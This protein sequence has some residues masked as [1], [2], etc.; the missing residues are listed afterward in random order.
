MIMAAFCVP[1]LSVVANIY[2][3][4]FT[5]F[6]KLFTGAD[7]IQPVLIAMAFSSVLIYLYVKF[8]GKIGGI[9][10]IVIGVAGAAFSAGTTLGL[11]ILGFVLA[12]VSKKAELIVVLN[13]LIFVLYL[14]CYSF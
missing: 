14:L 13:V 4:V 6:V 8:L 9:L 10:M 2:V 1:L 5:F 3:T 7:G 11:T 12:F